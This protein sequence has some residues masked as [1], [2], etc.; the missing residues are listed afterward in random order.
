MPN[1]C[2]NK[3]RIGA[4]APTIAVLKETEFSF[5]KLLPQPEFEPIADLSGGRDERWYH[6]R[7]QQWGTKWDRF[8]YK[9]ELEGEE[10]LQM[11]FTTAWAPPTEFFKRLLEKYP[12]IWLKCDWSE[13]GGAAG[14]FIGYT[15]EKKAVVVDEFAWQDWCIEESAHRFRSDKDKFSI[16]KPRSHCKDDDE[17]NSDIYMEFTRGEQKKLEAEI[18]VEYQ[19]QKGRDPNYKE[20]RHELIKRKADELYPEYK[21]EP[22]ILVEIP[23]KEPVAKLSKRVVTPEVE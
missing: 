16:R 19:T 5:E 10:A 11:K 12:D 15:D 21:V 23:E 9:L 8:D 14:I 18:T 2:W 3:V 13:E 20:L 4:D 6:W 22:S 1:Y 7:I 17:F